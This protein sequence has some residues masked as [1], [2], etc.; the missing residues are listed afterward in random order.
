MKILD[1]SLR[2]GG[3]LTK[4]NWDS[5]LVKETVKVLNESG[6][7]II[8]LGY[9]SPRD[10][11]P[12]CGEYRYCD[13]KFIYSVLKKKYNNLAVMI[14]LKDYI[15]DNRLDVH[16]FCSLFKEKNKSP[17]SWIRIAIDI[18]E[19]TNEFD[20]AKVAIQI[21]H[22]LE[23]NVILNIMKISI[24]QF[25]PSTKYLPIKYLY[26][27]NSFGNNKYLLGNKT[28]FD[29]DIGVHIH[30]N[31]LRT[32]NNLYDYS[33]IDATIMGIGRGAGNTELIGIMIENEMNIKRVYDL[34]K[35]YFESLK[36]KYQWG[37][38]YAYHYAGVNNIHPNYVIK[39]MAKYDNEIEIIDEL[40]KIPLNERSKFKGVLCP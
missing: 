38:N 40:K 24:T 8:E 23:Y 20:C 33:I 18:S 35:K 25:I 30:N 36:K 4:W 26:L 32:M 11:K 31:T 19:D 27:A 7:D 15:K 5:E 29:N 2:D 13:D 9:R 6:I 37:Y 16:L 10:I 1:C 17:F 12:G 14:D 22:N 28:I 21:L 3:Y 39:L 34:Q